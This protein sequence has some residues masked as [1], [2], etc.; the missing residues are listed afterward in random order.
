MQKRQL[1]PSLSSQ[2]AQKK[3]TTSS[4]TGSKH[5]MEESTER[6]DTCPN[7]KL[8]SA[9]GAR[10]TDTKQLHTQGQRSAEN[11]LANMKPGN[12]VPK[13]LKLNARNAKANTQH[14]TKSVHNDK[15]SS[16]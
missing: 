3:R 12:A 2:K 16:S 10:D 5:R 6:R 15:M 8:S 11:A 14:G 9:T 13:S 1:T 4:T 7:A